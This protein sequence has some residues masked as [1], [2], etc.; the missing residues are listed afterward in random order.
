KLTDESERT[1]VHFALFSGR[2]EGE[3]SYQGTIAAPAAPPQQPVAGPMPDVLYP[4]PPIHV[5]CPSRN[6]DGGGQASQRGPSGKG[7]PAEVARAVG[8]SSVINEG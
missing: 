8:S 2:E 3:N 7:K 6:V 1:Y 5:R 4:D